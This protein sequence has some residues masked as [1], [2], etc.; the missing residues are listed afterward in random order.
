MILRFCCFLF[1]LFLQASLVAQEKVTV[2]KSG[3]EGHASYRIPAIINLPNGDLLAFAEGR[4]QGSADFGDINLV[5]KRSQDRGQTWSSLHT[6]VDYNDLQAGN[7][8]PVV[9]LLLPDYPEGV[10]FLFYNT[11]NNSE[12]EVRRNRGLREVWV[13]QSVDL[14]KTWSSP[15]NITQQV[16]KPKHPQANLAY[17]NPADWRSYANTPGH[18]VQIPDGKFKGRLFV[19]ANHSEGDPQEN[20]REY[21]AHG[22]YTDDHG[23]SYQL[24]ESLTFPGSNEATAA[25]LS[26]NRLLMSVRNQEG[27]VRQRILAFSSD[28][29]ATWE[30]EYFE[31][32]LPD[33]V[34][35]GSLLAIGAENG[36]TL[37]A[38]ANATDPQDR[39]HL[40]VKISWDEGKTWPQSIPIDYT[41]DSKK[42]SWT[43]YSDL[44]LLDPDTLG[45]LYERDNYQEIVFYTFPWR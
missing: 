14:G 30:E 34:C 36:K 5:M 15:E 1:F 32:E 16:H 2:F 24:S 6:L 19:P 12:A 9:D 44:V 40:T 8:A 29:G 4:V 17:N 26:E 20:F 39:N 38:H 37:L 27:T 7:P 42:S 3:Q 25:P 33:P 41:S 23:K 13:I 35:Q 22:F 11:G 18:A 10:I 28:G 43:A 45:I 21:R 31:S